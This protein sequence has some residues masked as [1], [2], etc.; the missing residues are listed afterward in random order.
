MST[1]C[2]TTVFDTASPAERLRAAVEGAGFTIT[3]LPADLTLEQV[4]DLAQKLLRQHTR[5][6]APDVAAHLANGDVAAAAGAF[7]SRLEVTA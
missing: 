1:E 2:R 5:G 3:D 7:M 4:G 6:Y